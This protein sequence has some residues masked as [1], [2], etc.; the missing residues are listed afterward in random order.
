M[1]MKFFVFTLNIALIASSNYAAAD[2]DNDGN[3]DGGINMLRGVLP[4]LKKMKDNNVN[5][6]AN[7]GD[8]KQTPI[9]FHLKCN[10]NSQCS[11]DSECHR[12]WVCIEQYNRCCH[13]NPR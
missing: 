13:V 9:G 12:G 3:N 4:H 7:D 2:N 8:K 6:Q 1:N 10:K 11:E 5:V